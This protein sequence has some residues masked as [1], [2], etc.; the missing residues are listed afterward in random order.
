MTV[1]HEIEQFFHDY[2]D[3]FSNGDAD[4]IALMW[5]EVGLFPSPTGNFAMERAAF[6]D[7]VANLLGF[8]RQQGVAQASGS[9]TAVEELFPGVVEARVTYHML[10]DE[11]ATV[12]SWDH[13]YLLRRGDR[14][15]VSLTV[16]DGEM[17]AWTALGVQL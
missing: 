2:V 7:H 10:G 6:R 13:V 8:Y 9:L 3:A 1:H 11:G 16:A 12:A 5:D 17:A 15:R 14:W 4:A